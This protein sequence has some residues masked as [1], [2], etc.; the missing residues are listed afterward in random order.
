MRSAIHVKSLLLYFIKLRLSFGGYEDSLAS[1]RFFST[2][3]VCPP[4][5]KNRGPRKAGGE[6]RKKRPLELKKTT[7]NHVCI[8]NHH[9]HVRKSFENLPS[10]LEYIRR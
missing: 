3:Q 4:Y 7:S 2:L 8:D 5:L 6:G 10:F 1:H 9:M